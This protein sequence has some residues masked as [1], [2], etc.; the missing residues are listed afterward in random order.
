MLERYTDLTKGRVHLSVDDLAER[1]DPAV[2]IAAYRIVQEAL[3]NVA[4]HAEVAEAF[5]SLA[6]DHGRLR[7]DIE[8]HGRGLPPA[9]QRGD[10]PTVGLSGMLERAGAIGGSLEIQGGPESGTRVLTLL[11]LGVEPTAS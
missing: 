5:V 8:D 2:E 11:P 7:I 1:V 4:R 9:G 3:T 10:S 6:L